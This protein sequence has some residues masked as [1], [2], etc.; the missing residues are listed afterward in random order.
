MM[1]GGQE[2]D[3]TSARLVLDEHVSLE[4]AEAESRHGFLP[5]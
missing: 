3:S 1:A 2:F 5:P 4:H